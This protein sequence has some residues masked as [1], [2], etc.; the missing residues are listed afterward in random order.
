VNDPADKVLC[1]VDSGMFPVHDRLYHRHGNHDCA[2]A[3]YAQG[4]GITWLADHRI[5]IEEGRHDP[6][7]VCWPGDVLE[8]AGQTNIYTVAA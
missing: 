1:V 3:R 8:R 5:V 4:G 6:C 7:P 2:G